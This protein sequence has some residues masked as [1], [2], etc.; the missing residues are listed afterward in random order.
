MNS[1][2]VLMA[3]MAMAAALAAGQAMAGQIR[4]TTTGF[5]DIAI[6]NAPLEGPNVMFSINNASLSFSLVGDTS[7]Y[8]FD[9]TYG[10]NLIS[11]GAPTVSASGTFNV[12]LRSN[13]Q[14]IFHTA[15]DNPNVPLAALD[16]GETR[17]FA[18][19]G[20]GVFNG[21]Y[22]YGSIAGGVV[23]LGPGFS[24]QGLQG[25]NGLTAISS[26]VTQIDPTDHPDLH[27]A[28]GA[29][30]NL[31]NLHDMT[32]TATV[33]GASADA[34]LVALGPTAPDGGFTFDFTA[35]GGAP[36]Y[37]DPEIAVGYDYQVGAGSPLITTA[38]F[39]TIGS[40]HYN[41]YA[42]GDLSTLLFGDVAGG[43]TIDFR[44]LPGYA[45]GISGFSLRGV[46]VSAGLDP[47]N[48]QAF[49]TG[50]TFAGDGQVSITQTPFTQNVGVPEPSAW[51]LMLT[52]FAGLGAALRRRRRN[53][54]MLPA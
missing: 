29:V 16:P 41:I 50:L 51:A 7:N 39:P 11:A 3:G 34:P 54:A 37:I 45:N 6:T 40:S 8:Y 15:F 42:L 36:V 30:W 4:Y 52:G 21:A 43:Q 47:N 25:W 28:N 5:G 49:V 19:G 38:V 33:L 27:L 23:D 35:T 9:T 53:T 18:S 24:G 12:V 31:Y 48:D 13:N 20:S 14:N 10:A 1:K 2:N 17:I 26:A 22:A 32:F 44:T 46:D